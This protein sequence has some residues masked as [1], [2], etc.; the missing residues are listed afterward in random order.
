MSRGPCHKIEK[1]LASSSRSLP[2]CNAILC[3]QRIPT[4]RRTSPASLCRV[5]WRHRHESSPMLNGQSSV[6]VR[7]FY[8]IYTLNEHCTWR[9]ITEIGFEEMEHNST[10]NYSKRDSYST[11]SH[12][13]VFYWQICLTESPGVLGAFRTCSETH[14]IM[15][16]FGNI[17][18]F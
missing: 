4:Y 13:A 8:C 16:D 3:C 1:L 18:H 14:V 7:H 2:G 12:Y 9:Y 15:M 10:Y 6:S 17:R 11:D 5:K